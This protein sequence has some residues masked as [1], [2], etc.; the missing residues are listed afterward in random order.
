V[1]HLLKVEGAGNDFLLGTGTWA[2]RFNDDAGLVA[3]LCDRRRG[4]GADGVLAVF[5]EDDAVIRLVHRNADGSPSAFCANGTR[6]AAR[7]AVEILDYPANLIVATG[8][9]EIPAVVEGT[10]VSLELPEPTAPTDFTLETDH[11][12]WRGRRLILGIPH[13]VITVDEVEDLV[14]EEIAPPLRSHH[15]LGSDGANVHFVTRERALLRIRS[16]ERGVEAETLCCG[17]GV[18]SAA[19]LALEGTHDDS[20]AVEARS[21]DRLFVEALGHAPVSPSRLTGPARLVAEIEPFEDRA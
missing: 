20:I 4:I 10:R 1:T 12:T 21:G 14:V 11:G 16:F 9:T 8:W 18:V 7:A 17:S 5:A 2:R 3:R 6:C 13:L 15:A 19:L